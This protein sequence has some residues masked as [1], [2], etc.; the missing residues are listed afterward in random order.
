MYRYNREE[1]AVRAL[2]GILVGVPGWF[3]AVPLS[4]SA[5]G[6]E[7]SPANGRM[8]ILPPHFRTPLKLQR[9]SHSNHL[10][11]NSH[12]QF[13]THHIS[14]IHSFKKKSKSKS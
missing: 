9:K 13:Q 6:A 8:E 5:K 1:V 2:H 14:F 11:P 10:I 12:H 3:Q 4:S 7:R